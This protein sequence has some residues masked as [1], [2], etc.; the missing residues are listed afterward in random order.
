MSRRSSLLT[1][2]LVLCTL[3]CPGCI[4]G[5]GKPRDR[6]GA[7]PFPGPFT[8]YTTADPNHLGRHRYETLG[9]IPLLQTDEKER[10]II[11]SRKAGF[12][13]VAHIRESV[14]WS[15]YF[16]RELRKAIKSNRSDLNIAGKNG[17]HFLITLKYP[18]GWA[19]LPRDERGALTDELAIRGGQ[20]L[21]YLTMTWHELI[22]WFG[23]RKIFLIDE[24][25]SAFTYD[26]SM[27]H[28][29]GIRVAD[30]ALRDKR[31]S[32]DDAVTVALRD[33]MKEI[34]ACSPVQT[35]LAVDAVDGLWWKDGQ[36][37]KR[38]FAPPPGDE[39]SLTPWL[40][41][42]LPFAH[43]DAPAEPF[44]VPSLRD[45]MGRDCANFFKKI[46]IEPNIA[47]ADEMKRC[48]ACR[49]PYF[50]VDT[51]LPALLATA[52]EQITERFGTMVNVPWPNA[53][54]PF[55]AVAQAKPRVMPAAP[56]TQPTDDG[57]TPPSK[58]D[59]PI[60][61]PPPT[62]AAGADAPVPA[63]Q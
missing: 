39:V 27:S 6:I 14:D 58:T 46:Y 44:T 12:I 4:F 61:I 57:T 45:V 48:I 18:D 33:V 8:L 20:Q 37:L 34:Q 23:W 40:V 63:G 2:T 28:M 50:S 51:D 24:Q 49:M 13:D 52:Q 53:V 26:D 5:T 47:E 43:G 55:P 32:W 62:A 17:A 56:T 42:N 7:L 38:Q 29:I 16:S 21:A 35:D 15:R 9:R 54:E 11:Y 41:E 59:E 25:P 60:A 22:T 36:P 3:S 19:S 31:R 10:G 30:R 1:L